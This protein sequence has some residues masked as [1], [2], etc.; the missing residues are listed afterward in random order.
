M[1]LNSNDKFICLF[2]SFSEQFLYVRSVETFDF[3]SEDGVNLFL[4]IEATSKRDS[5]L[6]NL[7]AGPSCRSKEEA[8]KSVSDDDNNNV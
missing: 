7:I 6:F 1:N 4:Q 8:K 2:Q 5:A 3:A